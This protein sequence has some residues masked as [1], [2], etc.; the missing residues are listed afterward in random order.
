MI[1][2]STLYALGIA[3]IFVGVLVIIIAVALVSI[4]NSGKGEL[5]GGGAIII[6]PFPII[7]GTN[8]KS[9]KTI[10]LLS[11]ALMVTLVVAMVMYY[12]IFR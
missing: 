6:G 4:S 2:Y 5:E 10:L 8:R 12:L 3:L 1:D 7:F 9:V 11:L